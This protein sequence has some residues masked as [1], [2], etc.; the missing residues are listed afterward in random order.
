[1]YVA[2][3][4]GHR[5]C[6][7]DGSGKLLTTFGKE[8]LRDGGLLFGDNTSDMVASPDGSVYVAD[9]AGKRI[10]KFVPK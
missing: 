8:G 6:I 7:F 5:V 3:R 10:Q 2:T 4:G 1:V 9:T